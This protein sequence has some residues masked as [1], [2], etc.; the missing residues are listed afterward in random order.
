MQTITDTPKTIN[1]P[2][3]NLADNFSIKSVANALLAALLKSGAICDQ[4]NQT[5]GPSGASTG[6]TTWRKVQYY[7][8]THGANVSNSSEDCKNPLGEH[9]S[10]PNATCCDTQGGSNKNLD[11]WNYWMSKGKFRNDKPN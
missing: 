6:K 4:A 11:K 3:G 10:K 9:T 8:Y 2:S 1:V 5:S 7:C